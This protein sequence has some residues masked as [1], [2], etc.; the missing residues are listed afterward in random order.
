MD[1]ATWYAVYDNG[2]KIIENNS[3]PKKGL[4][5]LDPERI[6]EFG[7][8]SNAWVCF[9]T[10]EGTFFFNN[11]KVESALPDMKLGQFEIICCNKVVKEGLF[12]DA[13][14]RKYLMLGYKRENEESIL[15][16]PVNIPAYL[17]LRKRKTKDGWVY[18]MNNKLVSRKDYNLILH[19]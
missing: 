5:A 17:L 1:G 12:R 4:L 2:Q 14:E 3:L 16:I 10:S 18:S 15:I 6:Q 13:P 8:V 9:F 19:F 7:L 11:E